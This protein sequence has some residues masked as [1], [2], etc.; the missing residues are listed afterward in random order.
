VISRQVEPEQLMAFG[1][2]EQVMV[3]GWEEQLIV[4]DCGDLVTLD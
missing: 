2:E 4:F 3:F 1:S